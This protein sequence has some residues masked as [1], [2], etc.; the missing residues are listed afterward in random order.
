MAEFKWRKSSDHG[1]KRLS[2]PDNIIHERRIRQDYT[3]QWKG[4]SAARFFSVFSQLMYYAKKLYA[5]TFSTDTKIASRR[6]FSLKHT[7]S[8]YVLQIPSQQRLIKEGRS[9]DQI[10]VEQSFLLLAA[11]TDKKKAAL[12]FIDA[13]D[14][15]KTTG[16]IK[17]L[18]DF[19]QAVSR[20]KAALHKTSFGMDDVIREF[21]NTLQELAKAQG[22]MKLEKK[23]PYIDKLKVSLRQLVESDFVGDAGLHRSASA[24][25]SASQ[26][27]LKVYS[28]GTEEKADLENVV[29]DEAILKDCFVALS[30]LRTGFEDA[31][32]RYMRA[33][34]NHNQA[35][36][37]RSLID[38]LK[39]VEKGI[40]LRG[41]EPTDELMLNNL[42]GSLFSVEIN[43]RLSAMG[44]RPSELNLQ[45]LYRANKEYLRKLSEK[46]KN[47]LLVQATEKLIERMASELGIGLPGFS[48]DG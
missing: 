9:T 11:E 18:Y 41:V 25:L 8:E 14:G 20:K 5:A 33:L 26:C 19:R 13:L 39:E 24:A 4:R 15:E 6:V 2:E 47:T 1:Y 34:L 12:S 35:G 42:A 32:E 16:V 30:Q 27:L 17:A 10:P 31:A 43:D 44:A 40:R 7:D 37:K 21:D 46:G 29:P 28:P 23:S 45:E 38:L 36:L 22:G 3:K 48:S